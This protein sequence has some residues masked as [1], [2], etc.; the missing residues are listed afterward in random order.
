MRLGQGGANTAVVVVDVVAVDA[1]IAVVVD[2]GGIIAIVA[3][4]PQPPPR[5]RKTKTRDAWSS[6]KRIA[7]R[8]DP[9]KRH[10]AFAL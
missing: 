10:S 1:G 4:R 6:S 2:I 8:P 5:S 9:D 3:G 7:L